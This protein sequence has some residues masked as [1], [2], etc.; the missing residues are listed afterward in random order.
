MINT[1]DFRPSYFL[2]EPIRR[3][4]KSLFMRLV[5]VSPYFPLF[6][7]VKLH[8]DGFDELLVHQHVFLIATLNKSLL[9]AATQIH[10]QI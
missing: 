6:K 5:I 9:F 3:E 1:I 10:A 7:A 8:K 4:E 2:S